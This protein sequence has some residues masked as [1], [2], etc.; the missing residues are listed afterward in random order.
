MFYRFERAAKRVPYNCKIW[1]LYTR[2]AVVNLT[3]QDEQIQQIFTKAFAVVGTD[4]RSIYLWE[5]YLD[6]QLDNPKKF[7]VNKLFWQI[8]K[9]PIKGIKEIKHKYLSPPENTPL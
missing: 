3:G 1:Q 2:W 7:D 6:Y 8:A 4:Y 9:L 5:I